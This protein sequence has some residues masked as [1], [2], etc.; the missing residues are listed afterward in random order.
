MAFITSMLE[1]MLDVTTMFEWHKHSHSSTDV[2]PY[3]ELL[4]FIDLRAQ[5]MEA[6]ASEPAR[7]S[8]TSP[9]PTTF[10]RMLN[11]SKSVASHAVAADTATGNCILSKSDKHPLYIC[12][13]FKTLPHDKMVSTLK[14]NGL[15]LNCLRPGHFVKDCTSVHRCKKCQR[16]HHTLLH[17]EAKEENPSVAQRPP[18]NSTAI[19]IP[20]YAATGIKSN[21]LLMTCRILVEAPGGSSI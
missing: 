16:S 7:K 19:P 3:Q 10:K 1:L 4:E 21:L 5:A 11:P 14:S 20:S 9:H 2:P 8:S 18:T 12:A 17:I 15:C 6:S 13:K